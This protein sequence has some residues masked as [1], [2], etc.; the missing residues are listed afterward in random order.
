MKKKIPLVQ[1]VPAWAEIKCARK[2][3]YPSIH[4]RPRDAN[5]KQWIL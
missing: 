1:A 3:V 5:F 4:S 2:T